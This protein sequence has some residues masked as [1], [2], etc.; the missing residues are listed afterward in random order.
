MQALIIFS[1]SNRKYIIRKLKI[2]NKIL[3]NKKIKSI[4]TKK[5]KNWYFFLTT[6]PEAIIID[7]GHLM[8]IQKISFIC[9]CKLCVNFLF[10]LAKIFNFN[11]LPIQ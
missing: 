8:Q 9:Y 10:F 7:F 4:Y 11:M 3:K 1:K 2:L 6:I 5:S